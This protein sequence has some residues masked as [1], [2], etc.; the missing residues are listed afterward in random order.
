MSGYPAICLVDQREQRPQI[1]ARDIGIRLVADAISLAA[2]GW[3]K[4]VRDR[5]ELCDLDNRLSD[6]SATAAATHFEFSMSLFLCC[7]L[8]E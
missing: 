2:L 7:C 8:Y 3:R 4:V 6:D 1:L 5:A